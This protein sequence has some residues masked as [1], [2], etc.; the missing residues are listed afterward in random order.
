M[1]E[2]ARHFTVAALADYWQ[3]ST[4]H[5][6][7]LIQSGRL[8]HIRIGAAIR[9]RR[10]DVDAYE[11]A[12]WHAPSST[13]RTPSSSSAVAAGPLSIGGRGER[14]AYLRAQQTSARRGAP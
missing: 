14:I 3:V 4:T 7:T 2:P 5:I 11:A 1:A 9:I 13:D 12:Q 10:E 6:Y 8:G